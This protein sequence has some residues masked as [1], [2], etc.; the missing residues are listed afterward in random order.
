MPLNKETKSN[1]VIHIILLLVWLDLEKTT[2][3]VDHFCHYHSYSYTK[4]A[5]A[6]NNPQRLICHYTKRPSHSIFI[7]LLLVWLDFNKTALEENPSTTTVLLQGWFW[8][9]ITHKDWY[10]IKQEIEILNPCNSS[11]HIT[12][13]KQNKTE[14]ST[15]SHII[16]YKLHWLGGNIL[17][18]I[19]VQMINNYPS[20]IKPWKQKSSQS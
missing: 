4:M 14:I 13:C 18:N 16:V 5:L 19:T 11:N 7:I 2:L 3:V 20:Q 8:H 6:L 12:V 1:L 10:D 17:Y 15:W 9:Q